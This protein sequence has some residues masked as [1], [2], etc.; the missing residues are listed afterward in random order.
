MKN[1]KYERLELTI[2]EIRFT[3]YLLAASPFIINKDAE[4]SGDEYYNDN[5]SMFME[6]AEDFSDPCE[7]IRS[8]E[9]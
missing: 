2:T 7:D 8:F 9:V 1:K 3:T 5:L 4:S 6:P